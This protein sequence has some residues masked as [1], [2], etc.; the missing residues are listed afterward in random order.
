MSNQTITT[1]PIKQAV[2]A[3][4]NKQASIVCHNEL[5]ISK[6]IRAESARQLAELDRYRK[7]TELKSKLTWFVIIFTT[8]WSISI[9]VLLYLNGFGLCKYSDLVINVL[10]TETLCLMLGLPSIVV[11]H[12]FPR[13]VRT[14]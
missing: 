12:F 9:I 11:S 1:N 10:T 13:K 2:S 8:V 5:E 7:D 6:N 4:N 3:I 14:K